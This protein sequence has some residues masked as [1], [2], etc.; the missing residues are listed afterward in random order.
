MDHPLV[1]P[2]LI[3]MSI[4]VIILFILA[5]RRVN[6]VKKAGGVK[7][8]RKAGGFKLSIV[9]MGDNLKNQFELPVLFY[10]LSILFII[11]GEVFQSLVIAAWVFVVFRILHALVHCTNNVI[12]PTRF[13]LFLISS[14]ALTY[15]L[16]MA[17]VHVYVQ[18]QVQGLG[19][20]AG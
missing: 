10:A 2:M 15:M 7:G 17:F 9:N 19:S 12:F 14:L 18:M 5:P 20:G 13:I 16:V 4:P 8:L 6:A 3:Q 1:L 11:D